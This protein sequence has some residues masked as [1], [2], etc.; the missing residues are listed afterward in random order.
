M[1][2]FKNAS[3]AL[4]TIVSSPSSMVF[5]RVIDLL[6]SLVTKLRRSVHRIELA[7]AIPRPWPR[8]HARKLSRSV[9]TTAVAE[10][11]PS[12]KELCLYPLSKL[13]RLA[14]KSLD[15]QQVITKHALVKQVLALAPTSELPQMT[16]PK[17]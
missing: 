16:Q 11:V 5:M 14:P 10:L 12:V 7:K 17:R 9:V 2:R 13:Y 8:P 3:G 1:L 15:I 6:L 4:E